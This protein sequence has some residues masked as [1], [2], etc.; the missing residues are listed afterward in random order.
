[1]KVPVI[2]CPGCPP[3]PVN[4][5]AI[6]AD[7]LL[8][9]TTP[10]LDSVGR[11]TFAYGKTVH[12]QCTLLGTA[13]CL[14]S[15]GCRGISTFHNCPKVKYNEGTGFCQQAGHVC[16]AC[17]EAGFWDPGAYWGPS[18]WKKYP[19]SV[20]VAKAGITYAGHPNGIVSTRVTSAEVVGSGGAGRGGGSGSGG[21][22]TGGKLGGGAGGSTGTGGAG[23]GGGIGSGGTGAGIATGGVGTGGTTSVPGS[24]SSSFGCSVSGLRSHA[25][26]LGTLAA[27]GLVAARFVRSAVAAA[28][29]ATKVETEGEACPA[30]S[31][32]QS[33]E[34]KDT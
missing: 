30:S 9:G 7:Y 21:L 20:D 3:N 19:V 34:S 25:G 24:Q 13:N 33:P 28:G 14:Q 12:Q 17:S 1:L 31:S 23:I 27:A 2:K 4:F 26:S 8:K 29:S 22:A 18:F 10:A 32:T 5:V 11:P 15:Q 6:I 16:I